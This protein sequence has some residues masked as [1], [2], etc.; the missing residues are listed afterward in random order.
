[1]NSVLVIETTHQLVTLASILEGAWEF[2]LSF[3]DLEKAYDLVPW[4]ILWEVL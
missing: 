3:E 2:P 1:M 4:G